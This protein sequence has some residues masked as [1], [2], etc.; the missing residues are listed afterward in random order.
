M[1]MKNKILTTILLLGGGL[2]ALASLSSCNNFL[3][4]GQVKEDILE[5]IEIANSSPVT[6]YV[7]ADDNTGTVT[8]TQLRLKKKEKFDVLFKPANNYIFQKWEVLDKNTLE[9]V[10]GI[11]QF[12]DE[13]ALETSGTVLDARENLI[14]HPKCILQPAVVSHTPASATEIQLAH[15]PIVINFNMSMDFDNLKDNIVI[16]SL[17]SADSLNDY[18]K[19][20]LSP[21]GCTL[22]LIPDNPAFVNLIKTNT[23]DVTVSLSDKICA[24]IEEKEYSLVQ[25]SNSNFSVRYKPVVEKVKPTKNTFFVTRT[26][27]TLENAESLSADAKMSDTFVPKTYNLDDDEKV[28]HL[29]NTTASKLYIYGSYFDEDS[30]VKTVTVTENSEEPSTYMVGYDYGNAAKFSTENGVTKFC[31]EYDVHSANGTVD[32]STVVYDAASNP[33][34]KNETLKIIKISPDSFINDDQN[35]RKTVITKSTQKSP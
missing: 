24:V 2:C 23:M 5:A 20:V 16:S 25:D 19:P 10:E 35:E 8:P 14:I 28:E 13:T 21:D 33:A 15:T 18:F 31:I 3:N 4:A 6:F 22:T 1:Q 7:T 26:P 29:R 34:E 32:I 12:K 17:T 9:P 27:I 11:I 30:G